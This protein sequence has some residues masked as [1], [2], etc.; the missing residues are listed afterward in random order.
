MLISQSNSFNKSLCIDLFLFMND[1]V[2]MSEDAI[3][4]NMSFHFN[5]SRR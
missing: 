1:G 4:K 2:V 3:F 5:E